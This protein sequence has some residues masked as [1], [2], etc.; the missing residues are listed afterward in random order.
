MTATEPC[1]QVSDACTARSIERAAREGL[2]R[3]G[4]LALRDVT[5]EVAGGEARLGGRVPSHY[6]KQVAQAVVA[7]L[8]GVRAVRNQVEVV[9]RSWH[10]T[11]GRA[12]AE[13]G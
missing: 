3:A 2:G 4:Y 5:C 7:G 11:K 1:R 9:P 12:A 8:E 13:L 6:L 10:A